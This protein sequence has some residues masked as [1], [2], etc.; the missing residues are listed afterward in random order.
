MSKG[1]HQ[2][3]DPDWAKEGQEIMRT[4][5]AKGLAN[6]KQKDTGMAEFTRLMRRTNSWRGV[7]EELKTKPKRTQ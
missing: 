1:I 5:V 6:F 4:R 2:R 7:V 3:V